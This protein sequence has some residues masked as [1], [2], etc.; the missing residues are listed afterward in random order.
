MIVTFFNGVKDNIGV[1][2]QT[3]IA[4][5]LMILGESAVEPMNRSNKLDAMMLSV[6]HYERG[7]T[8]SK[9]N[10]RGAQILAMDCDEGWTI[11]SADVAVRTLDCPFVI[12]TTTKCTTDHHRFRIFLLLDREVDAA[13]YERIWLGLSDLWGV[14]MD[15]STRDIS[16][17]NVMP[18]HWQDAYNDFRWSLDGAPLHVDGMLE[19]LPPAEPPPTT[20]FVRTVCEAREVHRSAY[21]DPVAQ[22]RV[23][24]RR[25][26]IEALSAAELTDLDS[27]PI[28]PTDALSTALSSPRG[29]RTF[30]LLCSVAMSAQWHGYDLADDDLAEIG[31]LFSNRVG[32]HTSSS[33]LRRDATRAIQWA[34]GRC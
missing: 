34:C 23:E 30:S 19:S 22:H 6:A 12:H 18:A 4:G 27:S 13:E 32:R 3:D 21:L 24:L 9:A 11:E 25:M 29:G 8:R 16:R 26:R 2:H 7:L 10:A 31:R 5:L 15:R 17:L 28:V 20:N 14:Q 33:E 1:P